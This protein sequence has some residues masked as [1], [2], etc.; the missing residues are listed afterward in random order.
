MY[1]AKTDGRLQV[2][3]AISLLEFSRLVKWDRNSAQFT[4]ED[5]GA[6]ELSWK[7]N[8]SPVFGR[9]ICWI[10]FSAGAEFLAKGVCLLHGVEIRSPDKVPI[11][12][13]QDLSTWAAKYLK[14]PGFAGVVDTTHFGTLKELNYPIRKTG[15]NAALKQLC[16]AVHATTEQEEL[17]L[18]GYRFL[19]KAIRN[20]DAHAYVPKKRAD[21]FSLVPDLFTKCFN[22][23]VSWLP[24]GP[25]TLN[26]WSDEAPEFV[27]SLPW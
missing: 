20:R 2:T 3:S 19:A 6:F 22:H 23:L 10:N 24:G 1:P 14:H 13:S 9:L 25:A 17:L 15:A 16:L 8:V 5:Q 18:A 27:A 7:N 26:K 4:P 21:Q 12:P 11:H